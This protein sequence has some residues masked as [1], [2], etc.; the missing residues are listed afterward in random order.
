MAVIEEDRHDLL[1]GLDELLRKNL[2][3]ELHGP[4]L[5]PG[6]IVAD[7]WQLTRHLGAGGF[8]SVFE[9]WHLELDQPFAIKFLDGKHGK[10]DARQAF[11]EEARLMSRLRGRH[12]VRV[13]HFA[14]LPD[15]T[16][17]YVMDLVQGRP[18]RQHLW[19]PL[20]MP[21]SVEILEG[22]LEGLC[23]VH[24]HGY[25][26]GDLKPENIVLSDWGTRVRLLDFGL[27]RTSTLV[28]GGIGGTPP[29]MAPETVLEGVP[30][31]ARSDLYAVGVIFYEMVAGRLPRGYQTMELDGIRQSWTRTP[32]VV[33][34]QVYRPEVPEAL[35]RL[36]METLSRAPEDRPPT[37]EAML[38]RLRARWDFC[39]LSAVEGSRPR[40]NGLVVGA[41]LLPMVAV[42]T[43]WVTREPSGRAEVPKAVAVEA[44]RSIAD[45][46]AA[47][48]GHHGPAEAVVITID[49]SSAS[50]RS[51][52]P[53]V[54]TKSSKKK[55]K[56][57]PPTNKDPGVRLSEL[58]CREVAEEDGRSAYRML[59]SGAQ[60]DSSHVS[61]AYE[62]DGSQEIQVPAGTNVVIINNSNCVR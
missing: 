33:P 44:E 8:G 37:A 10:S 34:M 54:R 30:P 47:A 40:S 42:V 5:V 39:E 49:D 27:A 18:L 57:P 56:P 14:E 60:R 29:Y 62:A 12:L 51:A 26:H 23:E 25:A 9:A 22:V 16:P 6:L 58:E 55:N 24:A 52:N 21:E 35:D 53:A 31:D 7:K 20:S 43:V 13:L 48:R 50:P 2:A 32:N 46:Q 3:G 28:G 4:E 17:Y 15:G 61:E 19:T 45:S 36:I 38:R 1:P 59:K 41:L 11:L